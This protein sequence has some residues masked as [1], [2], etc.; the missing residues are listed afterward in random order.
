[1]SLCEQ[2]FAKHNHAFIHTPTLT[3]RKTQQQLTTHFSQLSSF[4][5][6]PES[7]QSPVL[8]KSKSQAF[9]PFNVM[10]VLSH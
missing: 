6:L 4:L 10:N 1:M 8:V 9:K 2:V 7:E 5:Y 3:K